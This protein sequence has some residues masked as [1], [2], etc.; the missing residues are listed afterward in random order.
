M[1]RKESGNDEKRAREWREKSEGMAR[2]ESGNGEKRGREGRKEGRSKRTPLWMKAAYFKT[3]M[4]RSAVNEPA[5]MR[6]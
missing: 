1:A 4:R 6:A 2:K 5:S 3:T